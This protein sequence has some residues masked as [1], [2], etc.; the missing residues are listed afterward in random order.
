METMGEIHDP[1]QAGGSVHSTESDADQTRSE[2]RPCLMMPWGACF[3][4][5]SVG[6]SGAAVPVA[7]LSFGR[8]PRAV[9]VAPEYRGLQ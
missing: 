5:A 1:A 7:C 6:A 3:K 4:L 8:A 9:R 2:G